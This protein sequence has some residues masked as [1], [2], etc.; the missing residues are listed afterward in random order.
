M[1]YGAKTEA[2]SQLQKGLFEESWNEDVAAAEAALEQLSATVPVD[3]DCKPKRPRAG[4]Q[5]LPEHLPRIEFRHEPDACQC[6]I[7]VVPKDYHFLVN[8]E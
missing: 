6:G 8:T 7:T 3:N 5:P 2:F 4:R 1:R